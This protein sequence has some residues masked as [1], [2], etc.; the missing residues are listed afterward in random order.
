MHYKVD[1]LY[2]RM[3]KVLLLYEGT[4][5]AKR[6]WMTGR[7]GSEGRDPHVTLTPLARVF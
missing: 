1:P 7:L 6:S 5:T 3:V 2:A 4:V